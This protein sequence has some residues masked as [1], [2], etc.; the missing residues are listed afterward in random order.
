MAELSSE[1]GV[2]ATQISQWKK[3]FLESGPALFERGN[4]TSDKKAQAKEENLYQQIGKLQVEVEWMRK[5]SVEL[6]LM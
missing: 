5:K 2:N 4:T 1:Y 6:G 3:Q